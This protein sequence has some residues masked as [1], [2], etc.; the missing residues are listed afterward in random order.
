[1]PHSSNLS[2]V[3][4]AK[5]T[6]PGTG[7]PPTGFIP[8]SAPSGKDMVTELAD[9]GLR[10]AMV[11]T[12]DEILGVISSTFDLGGDVFPDTIGWPLAGILGDVVT[13]GSAAPFT[14]AMAALNS[15]DGQP[16]SYTLADYYAVAARLYPGAKFSEVAFKFSGDAMFTWSAKTTAFGSKSTTKPTSSFTN[17][18]PL[19]GWVGTVKLGGAALTTVIDGELNIKRAVSVVN[20]VNASQDPASIWCG[21]VTCDGKL[22]VIME[23][24]T[25]LNAYLAGTATTLEVDYSAGVAAA[26]VG[27]NFKMSKVKYTLAEIDRSKDYVTIG[28]TWEGLANT[29]DIGASAGYSPLKVTLKNATA[30]GIYL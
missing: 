2:F 9:K 6:V 13:T 11:E 19:A 30:T 24:E 17:I 10:G 12:Y 29:T 28:I 3:G 14:H 18:P 20:T 23:D 7:V 8:V 16:K 22:T 25:F 1:M 27:V 5:E 4:I 26:A 15:G 21:A